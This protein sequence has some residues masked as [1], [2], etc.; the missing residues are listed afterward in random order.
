MNGYKKSILL[1]IFF[2]FIISC[3]L[4]KSSEIEPNNTFTNAN[5]IEINKAI[6][7]YLDSENDI[8]NFI[9]NVNEEQILKIELSGIKGVNHAIYIYKNDN[10]KPQLL[11][12]IDDNRKSAPETFANLYVQSGQ[13]IFTI[14]HGSRDIKKGNTETPYTLM[15]TSRS[16][17]NEEKE[18]ND[19][20][21]SATEIGD[22]SITLGYFSPAQNNLNNDEKNKMKEIDWYKFNINISDNIPALIDLKLSGVSGVDSM[23]TILNSGMEELLTVDSAGTGEG[24]MISDFGIKESGTYYLQ[25]SSKN[26]LFNHEN[27]YELKLDYKTYDQNSELEPNNSFEKSNV[28]SN[29]I[30]SGKINGTSDQD[31][32]QFTPPFNNKFYKIKCAGS[33]GLNIIM[34]IYDNNRNKLF[35]INNAGPGEQEHIPYFLIKNSIYISISASSLSAADSRYTLDIEKYDSNELLD[36]EPNNTKATANFLDKKITGFITYKNDI[37]YYLIK[38]EEK[39]KVKIIVK[40]VKDGKIRVSTT[41]SLGF[42]IK[43]KDVDSDAEISFIEI[44]DKKGFIIIE[45]LTDNFE[46]PY[47]ITIEDL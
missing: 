33:D 1:I 36:V 5:P 25:V 8:D 18:P 44:F 34:K 39:K 27:P 6:T 9:M 3:K 40:G 26:F 2:S 16:F 21:N 46:S 29:N 4:T 37:D 41:D 35:E 32:F 13:Y 7:G 47:T 31:F 19:N 24:E 10:P 42:I 20:L 14:T 23:I 30:I 43:S 17:L 11:K 45:P 28:I 15:I 38:S 22:K 12:V